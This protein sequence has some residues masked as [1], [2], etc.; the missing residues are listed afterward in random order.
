[1]P[2]YTQW[3]LQTD[4]VTR[5]TS[6]GITPRDPTRAVDIVAAVAQQ[7]THRTRRQFIADSVASARLYD[8]SGTVEQETDEFISLSSMQILG[9]VG[10]ASAITVTS[11][12]VVHDQ[13]LPQN[14]VLLYTGTTP[15]YAG[16]YIDKW[17]EGYRNIQATAI[18]GY[19]AAIPADLWE[20]VAGQTAAL[21]AME[22]QS[23]QSGTATEKRQGDVMA[24]YA[25]AG[26]DSPLWQP[27]LKQAVRDYTR[28]AG[29]RLRKLHAPMI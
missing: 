6:A 23:T 27:A 9:Y 22:A 15:I 11:P 2:D 19:A 1:M 8:G 10:I 12:V 3:P 24:K 26:L 4:I 13:T 28:P 5:L 20:A 16:I 7:V 25:V 21:M 18:W 29:K 17:P 14:R